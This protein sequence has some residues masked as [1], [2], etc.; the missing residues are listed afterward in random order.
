MWTASKDTKCCATCANWGGNRTVNYAKAAQ[1]NSQND[2]GKCYAGVFTSN[3]AGH[4]ACAGT[5]CPKFQ[6]WSAL[7]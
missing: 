2:Q 6:K 7:N 1:T 4:F 5:Y 3:S